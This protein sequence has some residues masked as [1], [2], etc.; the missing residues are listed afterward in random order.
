MPDWASYSASD[1]V[2]FSARAYYGLFALLNRHLW[3]LQPVALA[4]GVAVALFAL[5][6][7]PGLARMATLMLSAA[8]CGVAWLYF[9]REYSNIHIFARWFAAAFFLEA[10]LLAATAARGATPGPSRVGTIIAA[11]ILTVAIALQPLLAKIL[12]RPWAESQVFG[13]TP[14]PTV[15]ATFGLLLV[16]R[17]R[18]WAWIIPAL[19]AAY[20]AMTLRVL[21]SPEWALLPGL[22]AIAIATAVAAGSSPRIAA[23]AKPEGA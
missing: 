14:D 15:A 2:M 22:A 9:V 17:A 20:D 19:W 3:P 23:P 11:I 5:R 12:D 16:L 6:G 1:F 8:W 13:L 7:T 4:W 18:W 21:R 10:A